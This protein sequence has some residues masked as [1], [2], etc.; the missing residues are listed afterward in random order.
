MQDKPIVY[1]Y[2]FSETEF[3][4]LENRQPVFVDDLLDGGV[5]VYHVDFAA[6]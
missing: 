5:L 6:D 3:V 1:M 2:S 4:M